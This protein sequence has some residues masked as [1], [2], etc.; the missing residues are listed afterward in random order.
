[1]IGWEIIIGAIFYISP[2][3]IANSSAALF[4][5]DLPIDLGKNWRG[6]RILGEGKTYRGFLTG[7]ILGSLVGIPLYLISNNFE[8]LVLAFLVSLGALLGDIVASFFKRRIGLER[9]SPAPILD[10]LDFV[11]GA[12]VLGSLVRV[13]GE[14][15]F[16]FII[17]VTPIVHLTSNLLGYSLDL[18]EDPW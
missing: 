6:K 1:M 9:G 18:K 16:I 14:S 4:G 7:L 8:I 12:V 3:Y 13:P 17:L 15:V 5:G 11:M 2:A 10:Q